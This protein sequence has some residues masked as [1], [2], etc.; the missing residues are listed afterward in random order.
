MD[1]IKE[2]IEIFNGGFNCCQAVFVPFAQELGLD[3]E[4]ALKLSSGF[5]GGMRN[6]EICGAAS[7][8]VMAL[9]L[10]YGQFKGDDEGS[11][12]KIGQKVKNF[13]AAFKEKYSFIV[14]RDLMGCDTTTEVGKEYAA[15]N[16]L[17]DTVC[18]G[19]I[20]YAVE[21]LESML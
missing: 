21:L 4:T 3:R 6:A 11:K 17:R 13:S 14:C 18:T 12:E 10:K 7:G 20:K 19:L 9:G 2:A 16:D 5:G 1:K 8:A 15:E